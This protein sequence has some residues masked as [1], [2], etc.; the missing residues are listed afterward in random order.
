M[1]PSFLHRE[2]YL[3]ID[4]LPPLITPAYVRRRPGTSLVMVDPRALRA[5]IAFWNQVHLYPSERV[6]LRA[7]FHQPL[8]LDVPLDDLLVAGT[9]GT[10]EIPP[11]L[12][13]PQDEA[14]SA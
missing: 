5:E 4:P 6:A 10:L 13:V 7:A 3:L 2:I 11:M 12:R 9:M 14:E 8:H 1:L